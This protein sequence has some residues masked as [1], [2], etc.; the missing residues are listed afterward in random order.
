MNGG[1]YGDI[2]TSC[3]W[4]ADLKESAV[5]GAVATQCKSQAVNLQSCFVWI[6]AAAAKHVIKLVC[7]F[8]RVS[9]YTHLF[10]LLRNK[11]EWIANSMHCNVGIGQAKLLPVY[12][13]LHFA[14][15]IYLLFHWRTNSQDFAFFQW[16][17]IATK[18]F[19]SVLSVVIMDIHVNVNVN[20][21]VLCCVALFDQYRTMKSLETRLVTT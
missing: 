13:I 20:V 12:V 9:L 18:Q 21:N 3:H 7:K 2:W 1:F 16:T 5:L 17:K 15:H 14:T 11:L 4:R 6:A 19:N 10:F 8:K